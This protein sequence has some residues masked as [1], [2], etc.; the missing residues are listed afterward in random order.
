MGVITGLAAVAIL[1]S[2]LGVCD[3]STERGWLIFSSLGLG[4]ECST[5]TVHT[6]YMCMYMGVCVM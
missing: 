5:C 1:V 4:C 2:S 6:V 3:V